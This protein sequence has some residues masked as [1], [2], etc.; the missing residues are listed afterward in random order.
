MNVD[1]NLLA[2]ARAAAARHALDPALVCAVVEQES[3]WNSFAMRYEPA[4][5]ARYVA[6]LGL[7]LSEEVARSI[8]W[9]LMQ[10]MGQV[11]RENGFDESFLSA[12]CDPAV[13]L[14]CGCRVLAAK[15]AVAAREAANYEAGTEQGIAPL[16][17]DAAASAVRDSAASANGASAHNEAEAFPPRSIL[18]HALALWNG[19]A[20]PAYPAAV[21][22]RMS[23]YQ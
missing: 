21:L 10:V 11:A 12:L 16:E 13:G 22:A 20:D 5:R 8:S 7:S 4:F 18:A 15:L 17:F 3:A 19:G 1:P 2:L 6:P 23:R 9:G 14:D